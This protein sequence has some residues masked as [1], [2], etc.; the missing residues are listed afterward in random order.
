M[1]LSVVIATRDK[2]PYLRRTLASIVTQQPPFPVEVVVVD[3]GSTDDTPQVC[4]EFSVQ[5]ARIDRPYTG[6]NAVPF[7][8]GYRMAKG[9]IVLTTSDEVEHRSPDLLERLVARMT[10][11]VFVSPRVFNV[12]AE[13]TNLET[14]CGPQTRPQLLCAAIWRSDLYAIGGHDEEFVGPGCN[15]SFLIRCLQNLPRQFIV[16]RDL[17]AWHYDHPK[18][19]RATRLPEIRKRWL[20]KNGLHPWTAKSGAWQMVA[21]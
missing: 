5:Y 11:T 17:V 4:T 10:P 14:Y 9:E 8:L 20:A 13:G 12:D 19:L 21:P 15:D 18:P 6:T 3:D 2:A 1:I 7:N 16:C